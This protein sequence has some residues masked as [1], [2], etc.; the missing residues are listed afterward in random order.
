MNNESRKWLYDNLRMKG[1]NVGNTYE[2]F[3][4]LMDTNEQSRKWAYD[5]A[6]ELGYNVG[7]D[8]EQFNSL[9]G[10]EVKQQPV[11]PSDQSGSIAPVQDSTDSSV[12]VAAPVTTVNSGEETQQQ[13]GVMPTPQQSM[14]YQMQSEDIAKSVEQSQKD[15]STRME[16]IRKGNTLGQT[17]ELK[18]NPVS[19]TSER[20]YYTTQGDEVSTPTEQ[21]RL[22][23]KYRDE[24]ETNTP[25]GQAHREQRIQN[26]YE[27]AVNAA[28][29]KFDPD[30]TALQVWQQTEDRLKS[31]IDKHNAEIWENYAASG[32]YGR[33][34]RTMATGEAQHSNAVDQLKH[35]DLQKMA[36]EA[37]DMLGK[38]KQQAIIDDLAS[39]LH[40]RYPQATDEQ[41]QQAAVE[42][43]RQQSDRR[44][45][46]VAVEKNAPKSATDFFFRKALGQNSLV[47][48]GQALARSSAGTTGDWEAREEAEQ[49]YEKQGHKAVGIAGAVTGFAIDPL[50]MLS[51]GVG[52]ASVKGATWLGGKMIGETATRE[53]ATTLAGRMLGGVIGG[54]TNF[55]TFEGGGEALDQLK[56]GS[57]MDEETGE[58]KDG[59]SFGNVAG[60]AGHGL[61]MGSVT[62]MIAPLIG[63]V[64]DKLV[65]ATESTAGKLAIR[66]GELGVGTVA[67]GTIFAVPE[68][69]HTAGVYDGLIES[70]SD[71]NNPNYIADEQL[72]EAKIEEIR[73]SRGEA[74]LDVWTDNMAMMAGFK[75]QH[76]LKSAPRV[77]AELS[78]IDNPLNMAQRIHNRMGFESRLRAVLDGTQPDLALTKDEKDELER[79]GYTDLKELTEGYKEI[80]Q[81]KKDEGVD[82]YGKDAPL[83]YN[84]FSE[85][86]SDGSISEAARAKLYYYLTGHALPM[87]TVMGSTI[88]EN[89]D[90]DGNVQSYTVESFGANGVIT[91]RTF[92]SKKRADVEVNRINRQAE[93]NG[94][95]V[96][97]RH[98]DWKA[99]KKR[100][101][102]A[103]EAVAAEIGA[104]VK[105]LFELM[106]RKQ[107]TMNEVEAEWAEKILDAYEELGDRY[108]SSE[109]RTVIN[110]EFGVDV[111]KAIGKERNRRSEQEQKAVEEYAQRSSRKSQYVE[112]HLLIL[113]HRPVMPR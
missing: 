34:F 91:S 83:P 58:R 17:S 13:D 26:D 38:D 60:R 67:E 80:E 89:K 21:S 63:N 28:L 59:F 4:K 2:D 66:T 70:L 37:W 87:S 79:H 3:S 84:R 100:M 88:T 93:L 108:G 23:L 11:T 99:D 85:L 44:M 41:I 46:E 27:G 47:K 61:V 6:R 110:E 36:D 71:E 5:R 31:D 64:S 112:K 77:I 53:F 45:F 16:N 57:Y 109:L 92:G 55:A 75:L 19:G 98:Y 12:E 76:G 14:A 8:Y 62:G 54:A 49:R 20:S 30:N 15:F 32:M 104:P 105:S 74:M 94:F 7:K 65:K 51:A 24:W 95:D 18:F 56:W 33:E 78:R 69:A 29:S 81:A 102:E 82:E 40:N 96:G 39:A 72:R 97:E 103:C 90:A 68:L 107:E 22:N 10:P 113:M 35:K 48:I 73:N 52:G 106:N 101:E 111:D 42:M 1:Y 9:I 43:A 86:M 50:T 25:E